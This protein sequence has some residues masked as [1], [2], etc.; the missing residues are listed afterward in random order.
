MMR[1]LMAAHSHDRCKEEKE[2]WSADL[3]SLSLIFVSFILT[4]TQPQTAALIMRRAAAQSLLAV[5]GAPRVTAA[6]RVPSSRQPSFLRNA[7][8]RWTPP[9]PSSQALDK[10]FQFKNEV[11]EVESSASEMDEIPFSSVR[12]TVN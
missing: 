12:S 5:R 10:H 6:A 1:T 2:F 7:R 3:C 8:R 9:S 11:R 4:H